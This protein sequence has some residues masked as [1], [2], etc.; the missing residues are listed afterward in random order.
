MTKPDDIRD[1]PADVLAQRNASAQETIAKAKA[2][3]ER[4]QRARKPL[5]PNATL[6]DLHAGLRDRVATSVFGKGWRMPD[7]R[8]M[9]PCFRDPPHLTDTHVAALITFWNRR[10][11]AVEMHAVAQAANRARNEETPE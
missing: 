9:L 1:V 3:F 6:A 2:Q 10:A 8:I 5:G 11:Q 7:Y 4:L